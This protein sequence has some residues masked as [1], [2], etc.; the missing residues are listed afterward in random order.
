MAKERFQWEGSGGE[1]AGGCVVL[2]GGQTVV[3]QVR[4]A[5]SGKGSRKA[6]RRTRKEVT[7]IDK[8]PLF[9]LSGDKKGNPETY[10]A[11]SLGL[12]ENMDFFFF[13][14]AGI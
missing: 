14:L 11:A 10:M 3:C 12:A 13:S 9:R 5:P 7:F 4:T 6:R 1:R 8:S 2:T